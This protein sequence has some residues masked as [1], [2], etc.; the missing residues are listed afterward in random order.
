MRRCSR[1]CAAEHLDENQDSENFSPSQ[2]EQFHKG[3]VVH[4][5][6]LQHSIA[7]HGLHQ[8][9]FRRRTLFTPG[10]ASKRAAG[11]PMKF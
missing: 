1:P 4:V 5:C 3:R 11:K 9:S 10:A 2:L 8:N 6:H 7:P